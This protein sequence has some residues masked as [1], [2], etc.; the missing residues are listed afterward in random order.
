[1]KDIAVKEVLAKLPLKELET[2]LERYL[3]P[4]IEQVP[5]KRLQGVMS[6]PRFG[7]QRDKIVNST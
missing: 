2:S 3:K 7:G 5:D 1:M 4:M 6:P